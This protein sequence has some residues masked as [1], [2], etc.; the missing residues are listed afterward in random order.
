MRDSTRYIPLWTSALAISCK[1][2]GSM[3]G[4]KILS[5]FIGI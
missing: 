3:S 4:L 2:K 1:F 5:G